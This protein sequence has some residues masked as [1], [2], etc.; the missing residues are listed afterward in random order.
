[1]VNSRNTP[2]KPRVCFISA[3]AYPLLS[4][5]DTER[6]IG[7][8][9]YT[10]ILA[11]AIRDRGYQVSVITYWDE[12]PRIEVLDGL[13]I[14]KIKQYD[15]NYIPDKLSKLINIW[16]CIRIANADYYF[17]AGGMDGVCVLLS[18]IMRKQY[19]YSIGSDAQLNRQLVAVKNNDFS[20]SKLDL[21]MLGCVLDILLADTVIVQSEHQ[22]KLLKDK[23]NRMG[24]LI[25]MPFPIPKKQDF[26]K[27]SPPTIIWVG[28]LAEVKQPEIFVRVAEKI[29]EATFLMIGGHREGHEIPGYIKEKE[30]ILPNFRYL[31]VIPFTQINTYF[32]KA[33]ILVNTSLFEGFPNAFIQSW[34]HCTPVV[35]LNADPD[36][37]ICNLKLG[38]HSRSVE[39]MVR[40]I[41]ELLQNQDLC[42]TMGQNGRHYVEDNHDIDIIAHDYEGI[43]K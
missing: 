17:H 40:D 27:A 26:E 35:S 39:Q 14:F 21:G 37:I 3:N 38:F 1:M 9:V 25:K 11:K 12:E 18:K 7:P 34:M 6:I 33:M 20:A 8:D 32:E 10:T 5:R 29:P 42:K 22:K 13:T 23:Y 15:R 36:E 2:K 28:S 31:G 19:V 41:R 4:G 16:K 24:N 43:F 30:D